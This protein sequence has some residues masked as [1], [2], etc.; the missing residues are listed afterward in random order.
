MRNISQ[1]IVYGIILTVCMTLFS[2]ATES[3]VL[4][5]KV[6]DQTAVTTISGERIPVV[7]TSEGLQF[8]GYENKIVLLEAFGHSC[9][10]C[11]ASIPGYNRLQQK[12]DKEIVIIAVE[13]WHQDPAALK[14]LVKQL[15]ITYR[16]VSTKDSGKILAFMQ[17]MTGWNTNIGVPYLMIFAKGGK[18]VKDVAPQRLPESYVE[19]EI[20]KIIAKGS[21]RAK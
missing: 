17:R 19:E 10:P 6:L 2:W 21:V 14:K 15:R 5:K 18:L 13:A 3:T 4:S 1:S 7:L 16:V 11:R 8:K 12:Y 9:P 20:K